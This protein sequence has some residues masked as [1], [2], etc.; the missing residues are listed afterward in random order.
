MYQQEQEQDA[1]KDDNRIQT[2][3]ITENKQVFNE[4]R[5][6]KVINIIIIVRHVHYY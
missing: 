1:R 4:M 5:E 3:L 2:T 6:N